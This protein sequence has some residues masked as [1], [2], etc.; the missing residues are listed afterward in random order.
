MRN[1]DLDGCDRLVAPARGLVARRFSASA[2]TVTSNE[3]PSSSGTRRPRTSGRSSR[4]LWRGTVRARSCSRRVERRSRIRHREP[5]VGGRRAPLARRP[6]DRGAP[7][8][9]PDREV[10]SRHVL[11][12]R[13][14]C[15]AGR[16]APRLRRIRRVRRRSSRSRSAGRSGSRQRVTGT[17]RTAPSWVRVVCT[18]SQPH[19]GFVYSLEVPGT[20]HVRRPR[21]VSSSHN[22]FPKDSLAL[23]QLASNSGYHFQLLSAV[24]EVNELQKRRVIGKL[25]RHLGSLRGKTVALLGLAFKAEH[26]RHARGA[27]DRARLAAARRGRRGARLGP[28]RRR[29]RKLPKGVEIVGSVA[30]GG[31]AAPTPR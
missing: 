15:T 25:K 8:G 4:G 12:R 3:S 21:V 7:Q 2:R 17:R 9:R 30:R 13:L 6:R 11:A 18:S 5:R 1:H 28:G 27:V 22:C 29:R 14:G 26:R 23:K 19:S 16:T 31:A 20:E 10:D 24:I